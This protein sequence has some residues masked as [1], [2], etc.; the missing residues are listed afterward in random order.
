MMVDLIRKSHGPRLALEVATSFITDTVEASRPQVRP[1]LNG[2][3]VDPRLAEAIRI[4]TTSVDAPLKCAEVAGRLGL[5]VRRLEVLF[6]DG[7]GD[8][9]GAFFLELRLQAARRMLTDTRQQPMAVI[10][11][12]SGFSCPSSLSRAFTRRFGESARDF[13]KR[14]LGFSGNGMV[15]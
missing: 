6:Q 10:A 11:L 13:R 2:K 15:G 5:S 3:E 1:T 7:L 4:M 14:R 12:R 8:S 9:P